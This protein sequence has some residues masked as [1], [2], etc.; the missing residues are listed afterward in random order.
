MR[1]RNQ[2]RR[3]KVLLHIPRANDSVE[4]R[5]RTLYGLVQPRVNAL[6]CQ[7]SMLNIPHGILEHAVS[8]PHVKQLLADNAGRYSAFIREAVTNRLDQVPRARG[9]V[10]R[11]LIGEVVCVS[12]FIACHELF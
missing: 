9:D 3:S 6:A 12:C 7:L 11:E 5:P 2:R 8:F 4:M 1:L 10:L